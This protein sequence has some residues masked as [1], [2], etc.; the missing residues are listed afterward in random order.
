MLHVGKTG[1]TALKYALRGH[2]D[3]PALL[4][5]THRH[6]IKL[7]DL[8][9]WDDFFFFVRDP[10]DRYVSGFNSRLR[11]GRPRYVKPW[12]ARERWAFERFASAEDLALA[13]G[14][15]DWRRRRQARSAMRSIR[16]IRTGFASTVGDG[17]RLRRRRRHLLLVGR[18]ETIGADFE[19]LK[20]ALGLPEGLRLPD[21]DRAAH[22]DPGSVTRTLSDGARANV[23]DWLSEEYRLLEVFG[24]IDP[25]W[26]GGCAPDRRQLP[27][28]S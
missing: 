22:R 28:P 19:R 27:R 3:S 14:S 1:G 13:L 15:D 17:R 24:D 7:A 21:A 11:E 4:I 18:L 23:E 10:V 6:R 12:T 16:H 2:K 5:V 8:P 9:P 25:G 26:T 20:S